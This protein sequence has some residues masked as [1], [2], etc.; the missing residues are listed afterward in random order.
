[1][2]YSCVVR[3]QAEDRVHGQLYALKQLKARKPQLKVVV[4]GCVSDVPDWRANAIR[5]WT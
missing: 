5:T 3:Q 1:M 4:A 2:L